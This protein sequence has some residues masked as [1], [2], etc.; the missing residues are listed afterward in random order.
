MHLIEVPVPEVRRGQVL[1]LG[2]GDETQRAV[3]VLEDVGFEDDC[4]GD[5][6]P[7]R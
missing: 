4:A 1:V 5:V 2:I 7:R 6:Q 3:A